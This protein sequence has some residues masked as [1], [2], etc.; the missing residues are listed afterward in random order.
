MVQ[1]KYLGYAD[2]LNLP[3]RDKPVRQGDTVNIAQNVLDDLL[4]RGHTFEGAEVE[5]VELPA[6]H[7][8][9]DF[10]PAKGSTLT[11]ESAL[12]RVQSGGRQVIAAVDVDPPAAPQ[13]AVAETAKPT[14]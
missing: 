13:Q 9:P 10:E 11:R 1:V 3:G 7:E 12:R 8:V 5:V 14:K 4:L 2:S 6:P